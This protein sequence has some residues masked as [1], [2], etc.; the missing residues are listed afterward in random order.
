MALDRRAIGEHHWNE[1]IAD[2]LSA[3]WKDRLEPLWLEVVRAEVSGHAIV[4][5]RV[6]TR[7]TQMLVASHKIVAVAIVVIYC[8]HPHSVE[9]DVL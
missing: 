7:N 2:R 6:D 5:V 4:R 1:A 3:Q 8:H 9:L